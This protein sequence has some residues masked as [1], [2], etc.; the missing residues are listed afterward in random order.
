MDTTASRAFTLDPVLAGVAATTVVT[1]AAAVAD[2]FGLIAADRVVAAVP[3][4]AALVWVLILV[5][6]VCPI[7]YGIQNGVTRPE[8]RFKTADRLRISFRR[9]DPEPI[10]LVAVTDGSG[11]C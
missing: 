9:E 4:L 11:D 2:P 10:V 3:V 1:V 7:G 8:V 6:V 5:L